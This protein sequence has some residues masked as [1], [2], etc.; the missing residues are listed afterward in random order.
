[1]FSRGAPNELY[2][3]TNRDE[4]LGRTADFIDRVTG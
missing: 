1:L 2:N 3:Q 4:V